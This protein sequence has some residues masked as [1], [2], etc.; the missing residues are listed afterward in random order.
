MQK[1][2]QVFVSSTYEDLR[3]ERQH[4][5][6]A[7]L[8]LDCIPSGM[9]LFPAAD[10]DQWTL[11]KEVID[12]CDYY[13]LIV[14]G[15]Y[16]STDNKGMSYTEKEYRY[17]ME[18]GKPII[19]FLH[20]D[21]SSL[22]VKKSE[23]TDEGKA[24]LEEFR[25]LASKKLCKHWKSAEELG[26]VVSRSLVKLQ[27]RQPGIGWIRGDIKTDAEAGAQVLKLSAEIERLK[28]ELEKS[29]T[30][31]PSGTESLAQ[32]NDDLL[33]S[34]TVNVRE[35]MYYMHYT[36]SFVTN[37]TW[38]EIFAAISPELINE[39][40]DY[41]ISMTLN[42]LIEKTEFDRVREDDKFQSYSEPEILDFQI[43]PDDFRTIIV[44]L[45]ALG[46]IEMSL[47]NR[48][49]KDTSTYWKLTRYGDFVMNKLRAIPRELKMPG[50]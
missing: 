32:G 38:N 44:Q 47:K 29:S 21:P 16:G 11:I 10:D 35:Q 5:I 18:S 17:A 34:F 12:E 28:S 4:V 7:L 1:K 26:S 36:L 31:A 8:E 42:E 6:Q 14:G 23:K 46:L 33:L 20:K 40:T 43:E 48:S 19:A 9:E 2:Y 27:R 24:R 39:A 22:S 50:L 3:E 41:K 49:V 45:R 15:R 13:I 37:L 30:E 25:E